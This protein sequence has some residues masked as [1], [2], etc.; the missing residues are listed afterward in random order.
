MMG[1]TDKLDR[2]V[3]TKVKIENS[4]SDFAYWQTKS[5]EERLATLEAI[6]TEYNSW[7]Y[8]TQQGFQ[9]VYTII[10]R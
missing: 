4:Q 8:G 10:K 2:R 9:R 1:T 5:Y 6:R 3:V 7:K